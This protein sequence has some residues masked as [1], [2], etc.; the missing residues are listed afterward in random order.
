MQEFHRVFTRYDENLWVG[1]SWFAR[2][3]PLTND[4]EYTVLPVTS[5]REVCMTLPDGRVLCDYGPE[6]RHDGS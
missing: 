1:A 2:Y 6:H 3:A 5:Q 4:L